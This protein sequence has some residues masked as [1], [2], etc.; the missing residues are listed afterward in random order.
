MV[1]VLERDEFEG[2][3]REGFIYRPYNDKFTGIRSGDLAVFMKIPQDLKKLSEEEL[4]VKAVD[5]TIT[6]SSF[7]KLRD[8]LFKEGY[9]AYN[10]C[11][12]EKLNSRFDNPHPVVA[13]HYS[14]EDQM[15]KD[16]Q[17]EYERLF[18]EKPVITLARHVQTRIESPSEHGIL[19][20]TDLN[21]LKR[22][23]KVLA[24]PEVVHDLAVL[25]RLRK[26]DL[27]N[28]KANSM[29]LLNL[30]EKVLE[31]YLDILVRQSFIIPRYEQRLR[32]EYLKIMGISLPE[33]WDRLD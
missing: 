33:D 30:P 25:I 16:T 22:N 27:W 24:T 31:E 10:E 23:I 3:A 17:T 12:P 4:I 5:E 26:R 18:K 14:T 1:I 9:I 28:E 8:Y 29:S 2:L 21:R 32:N 7:E 20:E 6:M 11:E 15:G 19:L 13:L